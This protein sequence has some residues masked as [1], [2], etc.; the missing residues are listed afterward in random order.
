MTD[1]EKAITP[2]EL[3]RFQKDCGLPHLPTQLTWS[4][5][6]AVSGYEADEFLSLGYQWRD[7]PHRL[8]H[9]A[10]AQI[11][12]DAARIKAL[13]A[14]VE[15]LRG[16]IDELAYFIIHEVP[17]EPSQSQ[18]AVETAIRIMRAALA[19]KENEDG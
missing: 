14:E 10:C 8:V 18:G 12:A 3:A 9:I 19:S 7:K 5:R 17:G 2:E 1:Y 13:S 15:R 6:Q 16:Q 11:E 4:L